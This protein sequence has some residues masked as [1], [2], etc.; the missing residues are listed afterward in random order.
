M[1]LREKQKSYFYLVY[2]LNWVSLIDAK[3][4]SEVGS[5]PAEGVKALPGTHATINWLCAFEDLG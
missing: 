5:Q 3:V 4:G 2:G 1:T